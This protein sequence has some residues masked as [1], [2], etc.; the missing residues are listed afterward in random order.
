MSTIITQVLGH[1]LLATGY[2]FTL[3]IFL[4]YLALCSLLCLVIGIQKEHFKKLALPETQFSPLLSDD[5][6]QSS[7]STMIEEGGTQV[8]MLTCLVICQSELACTAITHSV[9][10]QVIP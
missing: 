3:G 10:D 2:F 8:D 1:I 9:P 6:T 4:D 7:M 5:L